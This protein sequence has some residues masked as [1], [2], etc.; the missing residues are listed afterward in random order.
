MSRYEEVLN[1]IKLNCT[2]AW[3]TNG[4]QVCYEAVLA[5][6][7][8][9]GLYNLYGEHGVGKTFLGW[10]L[11]K[12]VGVV[13]I[14]HLSQVSYLKSI[15]D[16]LVVDNCGYLR[17]EFRE[18]LKVLQLH[19]IRKSV[20]ISHRQIQDDVHALEVNASSEDMQI[21]RENLKS[22]GY[23]VPDVPCPDLWDLLYMTIG[24]F[25]P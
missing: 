6:L 3:L 8:Y 17:S 19:Q 14:P 1:T 13:Y 24:G 11:N 10:V 22:L 2:S 7:R 21:A 9:P 12:K 5:R 18:A 16:I 23:A 15:P 20:L 4:Q 25:V